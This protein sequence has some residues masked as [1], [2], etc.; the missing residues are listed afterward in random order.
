MHN[1]YKY[2]KEC[3]KLLEWTN[4]KSQQIGNL[5]PIDNCRAEKDSN[6]K[7]FARIVKS[8]I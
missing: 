8:R 4:G 2:G 3:R 5:E 7:E 1:Y 6:Y